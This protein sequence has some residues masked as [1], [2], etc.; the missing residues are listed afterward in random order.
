MSRPLTALAFGGWSLICQLGTPWLKGYMNKR[1]ARGKEDPARI[2]ERWGQASLPRP[3]GKL[4]WLHGASVGE[5]ISA[6]PVLAALRQDHPNLTLLVTSG[7]VTSAKIAAD[8]LPEG[9]LHQYLP[10][11]HPSAVARFYDHWQP[12][13][14]LLVESELWPNL[15]HQAEQRRI[16]LALLN[17]RLSEKSFQRWQKTGAIARHLLSPF[18]LVLAQSRQDAARYRDLGV[19]A[20]Q[21]V[22]NL[23]YAASPLPCDEADLVAWHRDLGTRPCWLAAS[24]HPGEEALLAKVHMGLKTARPG[25]LTFIVPRHPERGGD[26]AR[27]LTSA[28]LTVTRQSLGER[29][30]ASTDIHLGDTLGELGL[31]YRLAPLSFIGGSLV[32]HGGQNPLE[33]ARLGSAV[34]I[35]PHSH[36][37]VEM[38]AHL[39][40]DQALVQV[41]DPQDLQQRLAGFLTAPQEAVAQAERAQKFLTRHSQALA[42]TQTALNGLLSDLKLS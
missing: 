15:L 18:R 10:I 3:A 2:A 39:K 29:P 16:P 23:K 21:A 31:W 7:T 9:I 12:D 26:I 35:G 4:V 8:R 36:N 1:L 34:L 33:P 19:P 25:L 5:L 20:A 32:P 11:D 42:E 27:D 28:G 38:V 30:D 40:A 41:S 17:A 14:G 24:T 6:L 13:L 22:G 37:F